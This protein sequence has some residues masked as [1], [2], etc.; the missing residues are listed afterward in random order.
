MKPRR[1]L[2]LLLLV[3][4]LALAGF[5][6]WASLGPGPMPDALAALESDETIRVESTAWLVFRPLS[7]KPS[8]G[9]ILYPGGRVDARA[10][11]PVARDIAGAG[12]LAVIV[13]MPLNFAIFS[14]D[15]AA[16]VIDA[17]PDIERWVVGGHSLGGAMAARFARRHPEA[18]EG[19]VLWAAYPADSDDLSGRDI[20]V[21]SIYGTR[22]ALA[23][24]HEI[25]DSRTL[26][27]ADTRFVAIAGGNHA[28]F[29]SYGPQR[30]DNAATISRSTQ[31]RQVVD[32]SL[33]LLRR[34][35]SPDAPNP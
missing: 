3:S 27:P 23:S 17:F 25:E 21:V 29:G 1:L 9:L 13:P 12:Y 2:L 7:E 15:R 5:A 16:G 14:P 22:D 20:D 24:L 34:I 30:G 26:L 31:Q 35:D 10:Y 4:A 6:A 11:A 32:A 19:L 33:D 18:V 8:T 28:Q